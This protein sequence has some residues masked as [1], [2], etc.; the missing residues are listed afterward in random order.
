MQAASL[1]GSHLQM[2]DGHDLAWERC[3]W[4]DC[5]GNYST[6][7]AP[8]AWQFWKA[9]LLPHDAAF[10]HWA[11]EGDRC[12]SL[13]LHGHSGQLVSL[14]SHKPQSPEL[15]PWPPRLSGTCRL[16]HAPGEQHD[17]AAID[18][19]RAVQPHPIISAKGYH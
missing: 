9:V 4:L 19:D 18:A 13:L 10:S 17:C 1:A 3:P 2:L 7:Q 14:G 8:H 5:S 16:L 15:Q 6:P 11:G 12:R